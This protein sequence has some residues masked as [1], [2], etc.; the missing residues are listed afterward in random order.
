MRKKHEKNTKK[1]RKIREFRTHPSIMTALNTPVK[2]YYSKILQKKKNTV[3][4]FAAKS[5]SAVEPMLLYKK[6]TRPY[7]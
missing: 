1:T 2:H 5:D 4:L 6:K 3:R 7:S